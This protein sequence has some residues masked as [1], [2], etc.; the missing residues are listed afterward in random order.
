MTTRKSLLAVCLLIAS[1]G[2]TGCIYNHTVMPLDVNLNETPVYQGRKSDDSWNTLRIPLIVVPGYVQF[3]WG[4]S[5]IADAAHAQGMSEIYYADLETLS[6]LG[7]WT[8]R[9]AIV[10]GKQ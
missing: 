9:W 6:V 2:S 7:I 1:L 4:S 3:D 10:Y 8:Q 5:G